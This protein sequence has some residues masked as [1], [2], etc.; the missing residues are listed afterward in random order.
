MFSRRIQLAALLA[1]ALLACGTVCGAE[2]SPPADNIAALIQPQKLATLGKRAANPRIQKCVYW[3]AAAQQHG[4][5][6]RL[7]AAE[8]AARAGYTNTL[9]RQFTADALPRNLTI[10]TKLGC[11]NAAGMAEM[12]QGRAPTITQGPYAG[13]ELSVDHIIPR[14]VCPELDN[15]IANLE[16]MPLK[17]NQAKNAKVGAR[18]Q[19]LATDLHR[20]DL[21]STSGLNTVR[22]GAQK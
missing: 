2:A 13:D 11:L 8:A 20:A 5:D 6:P 21:L 17:M 9:A 18:Q 12:R 15:V 16:L 4:A 1:L 7:V 10:A 3:L 19:A 22:S 14:A